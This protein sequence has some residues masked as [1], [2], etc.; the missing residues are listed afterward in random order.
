MVRDIRPGSWA[1]SPRDLTVAGD[2][3]YFA[4]RDP[5]NGEE[6]WRSD[7]TA[8][9]TALVSDIFPGIRDSGIGNLT[10]MN[11]VLFFTASG[12]GASSNG[13]WRS[14]GTTAAPCC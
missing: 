1:S 13:L 3:I 4:A 12:G 11:G 9:G 8:G 5:F 6:L 2:W 7:G 14:D 10:L